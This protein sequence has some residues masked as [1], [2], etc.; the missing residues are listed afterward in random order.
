MFEQ[1]VEA[2]TQSRHPAAV[3]AWARVENA[4]CARRLAAMADE[5]DRMIAADGSAEREQWC[6]DNWD[7]VAASVAA[8]Q[9]VSLGVASHQL[10]I[11]DSLRHRLPRVAEVFAAG[12]VTYRM[13]AAI[14]SRT[15][16]VHDADALTK[17]DLEI[18]AHVTSWGSLSVEKTQHEIDYWVDRYDPA[19]VRRGEERVRGRRVDVSPPD[20]GSGTADIEARLLATDAEALDQR[21]DTMAAAVCQGDPRTLEQRRA[22]ALGALGHGTGRL[23]CGCDDPDCPATSAEPSAVI[24]HVITHEESL[25]DDTPAQWDGK[26]PPS[27]PWQAGVCTA[28][29]TDRPGRFPTRICHGWRDAARPT[30][31]GQDRRHRQT[32]ADRPPRRCTTGAPLH[33]QRSP[34]DVHSVPRHDVP[35]SR[36][37]RIRPP[38]RYR[39]HHRLPTRADAGLEPQ[40]SMPKTSLTQNLLGLARPPTT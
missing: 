17:V 3:G 33:S 38:L 39:P 13:V 12:A 16:L 25:S 37:Q 30:V 35:I 9:N 27:T 15:R 23:E 8:G 22:D 10:L 34:R 31:G 6:L 2:A 19:A 28:I 20:S 29:D 40:M 18:A 36:L 11:A 26:E 4:A 1:L 14:V 5:L 32:N 24:V 7:A 21:L